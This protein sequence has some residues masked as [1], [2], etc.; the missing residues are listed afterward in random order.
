[1]KKLH[2]RRLGVSDDPNAPKPSLHD[3][4]EAVLEQSGV[5]MDDV[6]KGLDIAVNA[7]GGKASNA[8]SRA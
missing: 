7:V 4:I 1:M 6:I 3:C 2:L 8:H 5:L